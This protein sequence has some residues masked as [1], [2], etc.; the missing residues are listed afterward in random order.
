MTMEEYRRRREAVHPVE[1]F[2]DSIARGIDKW[3]DEIEM[4]AAIVV[5]YVGMVI[6]G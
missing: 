4:A 2:F 1:A 5:A 6:L 3:S